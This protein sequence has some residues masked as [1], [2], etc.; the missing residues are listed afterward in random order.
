MPPWISSAVHKWNEKRYHYSRYY[1]LGVHFALIDHNENVERDVLSVEWKRGNTLRKKGRWYKK[2]TR[3]P[4]TDRWRTA[5]W[6][7]FDASLSPPELVTLPTFLVDASGV[8]AAAE[9]RRTTEPEAREPTVMEVLAEVA[10]AAATAPTTVAAVGGAAPIGA[11]AEAAPMEAEGAISERA[12]QVAEAAASATASALMLQ[13]LG[14]AAQ[15]ETRLALAALTQEKIDDMKCEQLKK[16]LAIFGL[17]V[18]GKKAVLAERLSRLLESHASAQDVD[19]GSPFDGGD[20]DDGDA[21]GE[22]AGGDLGGG[23]GGVELGATAD[24][25]T[26]SLLMGVPAEWF[27]VACVHCSTRLMARLPLPVTALTCRC[28]SC[29]FAVR[30]PHARQPEMRVKRA[31]SMHQ[32]QFMSAELK[33]LGQEGTVP[34]KQR[35]GE[36]MKRYKAQPPPPPPPPPQ[37]PA[38]PPPPPPPPPPHPCLATTY[39]EDMVVAHLVTGEH[40]LRKTGVRMLGLQIL[41]G[42]PV[43][44]P[45]VAM[46]L[47]EQP[48]KAPGRTRK[49]REAPASGTQGGPSKRQRRRPATPGSGT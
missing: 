49:K 22:R 40:R 41:A 26:A 4:T 18:A 6:E 16:Q 5:L 8:A 35:M 10:A 17:E 25:L 36:A 34:N 28:C 38:A 37:Q 11:A 47:S 1:M 31:R 42:P 24:P 21:D 15:E 48:K 2:T 45:F 19:D 23:G 13:R 33:R 7:E 39:N 30:N 44:P 14:P 20:G 3:A 9:R 12:V 46:P 29:E 27:E 32:R 43:P